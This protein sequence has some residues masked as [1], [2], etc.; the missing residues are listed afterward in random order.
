MCA[1]PTW[2]NYIRSPFDFSFVDDIERAL[3]TA[4]NYA[5]SYDLGLLGVRLLN[6]V[7]GLDVQFGFL[8]N[9]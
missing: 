8:Q 2:T 7:S 4:K 1:L 3:L 6:L 5:F 9:F